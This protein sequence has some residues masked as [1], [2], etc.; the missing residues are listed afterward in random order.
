LGKDYEEKP[1][2]S[3]RSTGVT[4]LNLVEVKNLY[5]TFGEH[6][7]LDDISFTIERGDIVAVIGPN[8]AGKTVLIKTLLGILKPASGDIVFKKGLK[9]GYAPQKLEFDRNFPM[10]VEE[11]MLMQSHDRIIFPSKEGKQKISTLLDEVGVADLG[12]KKIG[13]LSGGQLQR[14]LIAAS[15]AGDP[16]IVYLDEPSA[17]V[18]IGGEQTIYHLIDNLHKT[19]GLT[20]VLVSHDI[21]FVYRA[22]NKVLC[23]NKRKLCFGVPEVALTAEVMNKVFLEM[24]TPYHHKDHEET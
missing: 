23:L 2:T 8:G 5:V 17:G 16:D 14:V 22:S 20:L 7:V 24:A 18:D 4:L 19:R 3:E 13:D 6:T 21:D 9:T 1:G 15:L 11:F 10:T 12:L